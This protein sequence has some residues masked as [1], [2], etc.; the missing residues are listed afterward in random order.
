M[1]ERVV[2]SAI[3]PGQNQSK[4]RQCIR[5]K[6]RRDEKKRIKQTEDVSRRDKHISLL[7][8]IIELLTI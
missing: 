6:V 1:S 7:E 8:E 2:N 5:H 4:Q 3:P